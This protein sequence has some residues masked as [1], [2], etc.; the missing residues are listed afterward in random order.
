MLEIKTTIEIFHKTLNS[1][2]TDT[3]DLQNTKQLTKE[4]WVSVESLLTML[5]ESITYKS[6]ALYLYAIRKELKGEQK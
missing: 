2:E 6:Q 4:K 1:I 5:D 3:N